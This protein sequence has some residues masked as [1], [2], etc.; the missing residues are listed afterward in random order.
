M[1]RTLWAAFNLVV[2]TVPMSLI[3]IGAAFLGVRG[4]IYDRLAHLWARW[5]LR[6]SGVRVRVEGLERLPKDAP[7]IIASNHESWY[8]VFALAAFIPGPYRF[9]AKKELTRIPLFGRAW[10]AA[11]HISVDRSDR[12]AAIRTLDSAGRS[13]RE[14]NSS[15]VIFPEGT[16]SP[17]GELL[18]FK[19]GA[20]MLAIHTGVDIVPVGV[21]GGRR[22]LPKGSWRVRAGELIVRFGAPIP[23]A[24]YSE[25]NRDALIQRVRDEIQRLKGPTASGSVAGGTRHAGEQSMD[26]A[27]G[28]P[29]ERPSDPQ[30]PARP[31]EP[32][33]RR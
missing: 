11:G 15:I 1:I 31:A 23:T 28:P 16:R 29:L 19:K 32:W 26:A 24:D 12:Q 6:V 33:S 3:A 18:P 13:I 22:I 20:F 8:D 5:A 7:R 21:S 10:Q 9:I 25:S 2:A 30:R 4:P 14:D 27:A 17:T